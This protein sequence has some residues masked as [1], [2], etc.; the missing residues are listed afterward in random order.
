MN[1]LNPQDVAS[2]SVLKDAASAAIYGSR[3]ANGVILITTKKGR[4]G[5]FRVNY[6]SLFSNARPSNIIETVSNY[7]D[8]M[9]LVNEGFKNSDPNVNPTFS[10][11]MIDLWRQHEG[12]RKSTRL[13]SSH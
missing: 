10:Q 11:E 2:V 13:N 12:D 8:Y 3:A 1:L 6:N 7:A 5:D 4:S 9:E